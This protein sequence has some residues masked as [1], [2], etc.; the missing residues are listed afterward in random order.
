MTFNYKWIG[1]RL[2]QPNWGPNAKIWWLQF[3]L[4]FSFAHIHTSMCTLASTRTRTHTYAH[5]REHTH[6]HTHTHTEAL[7]VLLEELCGCYTV[8]ANLNPQQVWFKWVFKHVFPHCHVVP[9]LSWVSV[10]YENSMSTSN[11]GYTRKCLT[12]P[13]LAQCWECSH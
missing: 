12:E 4:K 6:T 9:L 13:F 8:S 3:W 2:S 5:A 7:T 11:V 1:K 10:I